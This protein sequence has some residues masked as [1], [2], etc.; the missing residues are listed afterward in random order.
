MQ[1]LIRLIVVINI[2]FLSLSIG[3]SQKEGA[4]VKVIK[5]RRAKGMVIDGES[6]TKLYDE[7]HLRKDDVDFFCDSAVRYEKKMI[8]LLMAMLRC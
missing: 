1:I 6:V 4:G 2:L 5:T 8:L 7:V 3:Y